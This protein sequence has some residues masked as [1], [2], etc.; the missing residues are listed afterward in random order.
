MTR[1]RHEELREFL[2]G[3]VPEPLA[4]IL[5]AF[6]G[7]GTTLRDALATAPLRDLLGATGETNVQDEA[8]ARLDVLANETF[9]EALRL[10]GVARLI[11][12]EEPEPLELGAG[13]YTCCF[14]PLDGS[15]N[16]GVASVG[17]V[18]GV[19]E[20]WAAAPAAGT[21]A[22]GRSLVASAFIVYG[23]PTV[24]VLAVPGRADGFAFDPADGTWRLAFPSIGA[25]A[26][27]YASINWMYRE[28]WSER[29]ARAVD[30]ASTGLRGRYSGSMVE[31]VLRVLL[32]GGV[33]LY[34]EDTS[35]PAGKLRMLYEINPIGFIMEAAGGAASDGTRAVLDV[36]VTQPHQR[37]PLVAGAADAVARYV[38]AC[39]TG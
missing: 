22:T 31:D 33:F 16:I 32:S 1:P 21:P 6:A 10:P 36:P 14:D 9:R 19:Y 37:G 20:G 18:I 11:S 25:P 8:T 15:S 23:L 26:A 13:P 35:S 28:R 34:P 4:E 2:A 7:A 12:E 24:L 39:T 27:K 3:R 30:A 5:T 38:A 17:S 29:V